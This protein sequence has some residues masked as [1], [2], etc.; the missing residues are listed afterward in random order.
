[1]KVKGKIVI[2]QVGETDGVD[3]GF[4]ASRA[5][6]VGVIIAN[7][8]EKG[9][10]IFPELHFI[11]ASDITNTDAQIVQN[12]LKS[13]RTPMAHLTSVKTLLSVKPAPTIATFSARGPNPID[14][15]ILKVCFLSQF[16]VFYF[17][18]LEHFYLLLS[19]IVLA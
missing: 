5:G 11:P 6:A 16:F 9:D 8:L 17:F 4:Q 19:V 18:V 14:S 3:K 2:C 15:T 12:Y 10:E 7:D 1:M 13:T